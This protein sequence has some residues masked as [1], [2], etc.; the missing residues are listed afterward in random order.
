MSCRVVG[1]RMGVRCLLDGEAEIEVRGV[2]VA[3]GH[4]NAKFSVLLV[5]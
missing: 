4:L 5:A 1:E 2:V 3:K